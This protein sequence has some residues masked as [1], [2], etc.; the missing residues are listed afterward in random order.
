LSI[1]LYKHIFV[2]ELFLG[3]LIGIEYMIY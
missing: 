3:Y 2:Y 1:T